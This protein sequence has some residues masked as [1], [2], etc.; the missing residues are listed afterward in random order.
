[1]R[2]KPSCLL[3]YLLSF[4]S[5]CRI[6]TKFLAEKGSRTSVISESDQRRQRKGYPC[7]QQIR[8]PDQGKRSNV[9]YM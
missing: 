8:F 9:K 4:V 1:M 2:G 5:P 6:H 3:E 7:L